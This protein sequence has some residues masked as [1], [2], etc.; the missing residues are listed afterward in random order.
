MDKVQQKLLRR[1]TTFNIL[2]IFFIS[3]T[4]LSFLGM[5]IFY[6]NFYWVL[7]GFI[8][9]VASLTITIFFIIKYVD[10]QTDLKGYILVPILI[11]LSKPPK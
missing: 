10:A 7:S 2:R 4:L 5:F 9:F 11:N 3:L 6:Q 8:T 1:V